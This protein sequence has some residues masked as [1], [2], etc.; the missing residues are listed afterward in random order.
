MS[1]CSTLVVLKVPGIIPPLRILGFLPQLEFL[2]IFYLLIYQYTYS[3]YITEIPLLGVKCLP[4][5]N[6]CFQMKEFSL[7][8]ADFQTYEINASV[9]CPLRAVF[10]N[11][12]F[13]T[14][15]CTCRMTKTLG[16]ILHFNNEKLFL[17]L[18]NSKHFI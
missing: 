17:K 12:S 16:C 8:N 5:E 9:S 6:Y 10:L 3:I 11:L 14:S 13:F 1:Y 2:F 18:E 7:N 15:G 4:I